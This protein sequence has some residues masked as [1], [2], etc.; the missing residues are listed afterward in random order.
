MQEKADGTRRV[1][2]LPRRHVPAAPL[3]LILSDQKPLQKYAISAIVFID[4]NAYLRH[5]STIF[6]LS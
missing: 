1:L 6:D 4:P 2:L 3:L 5:T